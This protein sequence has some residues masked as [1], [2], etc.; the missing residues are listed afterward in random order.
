MF[1]GVR[2]IYILGAPVYTAA[3]GSGGCCIGGEG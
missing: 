3:S 2:M 1:T